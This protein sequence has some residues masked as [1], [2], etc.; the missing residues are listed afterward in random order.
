MSAPQRRNDSSGSVPLAA[1][2]NTLPA[3]APATIGKYQIVERIGSG[4]FATVFKAWDPDIKRAVAVKVCTL[5]PDMHARFFQE[6]ELAGRLQHP[7][8][9]TVFDTGSTASG[10]SSS[11]SS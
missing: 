11:R 1:G 10:P 5:G 9:T 2:W 3:G 7:N 8:I 4:G 6:A